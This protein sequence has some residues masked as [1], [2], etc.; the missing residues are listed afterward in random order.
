MLSMLRPT[1]ARARVIRLVV[2]SWPMPN[3]MD[4]PTSKV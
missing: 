4:E 1:A 2:P 3:I